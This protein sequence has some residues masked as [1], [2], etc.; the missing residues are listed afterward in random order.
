MIAPWLFDNPILIKHVRSRLR[1][2]HRTSLVLVVVIICGCLLWGGLQQGIGLQQ[3]I[4]LQQGGLFV[5]YFALQGLCLHVIGMSQ[6]ASSIGQVNDSGVLDFHRI[7][8]LPPMTTA[9]GFVLGAP[10]REYLVAVLIV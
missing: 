3:V 10:I 8:P 9:L 5:T 6:V 2:T 7:S 4:G 1:R